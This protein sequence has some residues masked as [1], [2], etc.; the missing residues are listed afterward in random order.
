MQ[1]FRRVKRVAHGAKD[2]KERALNVESGERLVGERF[3]PALHGLEGATLDERL[4]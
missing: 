2:L 1:V 3:E 4:G